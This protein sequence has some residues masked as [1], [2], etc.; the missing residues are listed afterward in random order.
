MKKKIFLIIVV[1]MF[2]GLFLF[3]YFKSKDYK[4]VYNV[5]NF[6]IQES[7]DKKYNILYFKISNKKYEYDYALNNKYSNRRKLISSVKKYSFDNG[8]CINFSINKLQTY[9]LCIEDGNQINYNNL[10]NDFVNKYKNNIK[11]TEDNYNNISIYNYY[12]STFA[13]WNYKGIY[14]INNKDKDE[15]KLFLKDIY[16][17]NL[18][19]LNNEYLF[20]PNYNLNYSF[21][22]AYIIN[23]KTKENKLISFDYDISYKSYILGSYKD[24]IYLVDKKNEKEYEVNLKKKKVNELQGKIYTYG[25]KDISLKKLANKEYSF[26]FKKA[27]NYVIENNKLYLN[28][29]ES[30]NKVYI[31][32]MKNIDTYFYDN[33]NFYYLIDDTLYVYNIKLGKL[34]LMQSFEWNFNNK[35]TIFIYNQNN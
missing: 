11:E 20:I 23:L 8:Q 17:D 31:M 27:I 30:N 4:I 9:P 2:I 13:I 7:Y 35:N 10:D 28:Y 16:V 19:Y 18:S 21:N 14:Y 12:N 29:Y 25:W 6:K 1:S 26:K 24:S 34:K 3:F 22:E 15:I 5:D 33:D 32:S